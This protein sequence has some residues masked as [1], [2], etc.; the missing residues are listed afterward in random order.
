MTNLNPTVVG[1]TLSVTWKA[2][3][4]QPS[5]YRV[6][7]FIGN[8]MREFTSTATTSATFNNV[9]PTTYYQVKVTAYNDPEQGL[10]GGFGPEVGTGMK[11]QTT[12]PSKLP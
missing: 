10:G 8:V 12:P 3:T 11:V 5:R 1:T 9:S 6:K 7:L 4:P 2:P